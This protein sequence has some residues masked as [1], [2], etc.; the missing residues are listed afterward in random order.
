MLRM[1]PPPTGSEAGYTA[2]TP[3]E[4]YDRWSEIYDAE[5]NPL[6]ALEERHLP[7][8]LADVRG[9]SV[10]DLGCGTGRHAIRLA[11]AGAAVTALDLSEG[12]LAKA[13]A[14]P[15]AERIRFFAHDVAAPLPLPDASFD[16][17][18]CTLMLEHVAD[19]AV[20]LRE[21]RRVATP[22]ARVI[23]TEL[24]PAMRL[25]GIS[26]RFTDPATGQETRPTSHGHTISDFIMASRAAGLK[27]LHISEHAVDDA[28]ADRSPRA[29]KYIGWP[30]LLLMR[31][32]V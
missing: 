15:G 24:H 21:M 28:I 3:R 16:L 6:I 5:D 17:V 11:A 7:P 13:R 31:Y 4:G 1:N 2:I 10:L 29:A 23:I 12:M 27:L 19:L 14:K 20:A 8:H 30:M 18:L 26:A 9:R 25:R 32:D 22:A